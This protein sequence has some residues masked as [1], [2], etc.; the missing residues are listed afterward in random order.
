MPTRRS[1]EIQTT[2]I[3]LIKRLCS[4]KKKKKSFHFPGFWGGKKKGKGVGGFSR[5]HA[6]EM[7]RATIVFCS[8]GKGA[9]QWDISLIFLISRRV[10]LLSSSWRFY[11]QGDEAVYLFVLI[12]FSCNKVE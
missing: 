10:V 5:G 9:C 1:W 8:F 12:F 2:P 7:Y 4:L 11:L 6:Q 3:Y